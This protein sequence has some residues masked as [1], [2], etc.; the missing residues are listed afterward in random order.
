M[1]LSK[2]SDKKKIYRS[3]NLQ[4]K[5]PRVKIKSRSRQKSDQVKYLHDGDDL[6]RANF[7]AFRKHVVLV[8]NM[9]IVGLAKLVL[10]ALYNLLTLRGVADL[11]RRAS[12]LVQNVT[13]QSQ[14]NTR[15][16]DPEAV[17]AAGDR[18]ADEQV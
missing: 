8:H 15:A 9:K 17:H 16:A 1:K 6:V 5:F 18:D 14:A 2:E 3:E 12:A 13:R 11:G 10:H 4:N 7:H